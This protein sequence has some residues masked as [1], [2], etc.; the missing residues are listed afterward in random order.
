MGSFKN[1]DFKTVC[2][3]INYP[4]LKHCQKITMF[5]SL[6]WKCPDTLILDSGFLRGHCW[7]ST[8][9]ITTVCNGYKW[10]ISR[11]LPIRILQGYCCYEQTILMLMVIIN[12]EDNTNSFR[13]VMSYLEAQTWTRGQGKW[14]RPHHFPLRKGIFNPNMLLATEQPL[15]HETNKH[16]FLHFIKKKRKELLIKGI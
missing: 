5:I 9:E 7:S 2:V 13:I 4:K 1:E 15:V 3:V 11:F 12:T 8:L 16:S 14:E 6:T 10:N